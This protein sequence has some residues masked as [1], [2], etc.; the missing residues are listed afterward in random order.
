MDECVH[1]MNPEWCGTCLK[2]DDSGTGQSGSYGW[3]GGE[4]KQD[5]LNDLC[6]I[7]GIKRLATSN[8]SSLPTEVF[9]EAASQVGVAGGA[10]PEVTERIIRKAGMPYSADYDSRATK[11]GGGSTVT[12]D[13][14]QALRKALRALLGA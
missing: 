10:M 13:G 2:I 1:G 8:G 7:L 4:T 12:L 11:S 5:V 9:Q 6:D 14:M 3:H